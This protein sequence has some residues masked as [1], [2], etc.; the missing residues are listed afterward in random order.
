MK[1]VVAREI[2]QAYPSLTTGLV[3]ARGIDNARKAAGVEEL[4]TEAEAYVR[5]R[6]ELSRLAKEP[7]IASWRSTYSSFGVKPSRYNSAVESLLRRVLKEGSLPRINKLVDLCNSFSLKSVLPIAA[8]DLDKVQ[9]DIVIKFAEGHERFLGLGSGEVGFPAPGEVIYTDQVEALSRRWNWRECDKAK[10]L[11]TTRNV[12]L[13]VEGIKQIGREVVEETTRQLSVEVQ[14]FCG[15]SVCH[16]LLDK[17]NQEA[18][19]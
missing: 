10:V 15:G 2:W 19:F 4:L 6:L 17:E 14:K 9:G 11:D 5:S 12:L 1:Y 13:T 7:H 18:E 3:V 8:Y 16:F